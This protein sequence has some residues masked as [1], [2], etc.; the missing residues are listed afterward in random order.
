[1]ADMGLNTSRD[2]PKV[3][4]SPQA[5]AIANGRLLPGILGADGLRNVLLR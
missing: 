3:G 5:S 2:R 4:R 1:M